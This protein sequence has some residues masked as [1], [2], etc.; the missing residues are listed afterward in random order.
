LL[1]AAFPPL[2]WWPVAFVAVAPL[3]W[4][5]TSAG[6]RR[7]ALLGLAFG[8]G[9]Y[10]ATIY[11]ILLFGELAW[12]ALTLLC[13]ASTALFGLVAPAL[14]RRRRPVMQALG[15]AALW[16]VV[17]WIRGSWPLE[18][19]TWGSLGVS[20][21]DN[22]L[23]VRLATVTGVWGVTFVVVL[24]N[25]LVLQAIVGDGGALRRLARVGAALVL[26]A[27]PVVIPFSVPDGRGLDVATL[28]VDVRRAAVGSSID[29]DLGVARLNMAMHATLADDPPDLVVWGEGALDPGA[30]ND[31]ATFDA[32]RRAIAEV[33]SPTLIGSVLDDPDGTQHTS[34]L[35]FDGSGTPVDRYDKVHLVPFGE[36]VPWRRSLDWISA[37]EQI[38]VDRTPGESVHTVSTEGIPRIGTPICFEN[39]FPSLTRAFVRAGAGFLVVPVNNASYETTAASAQHLQMS[40]MRAV[41]NGRW[42]IDAA[43]S[44]ITAFVDPTGRVVAQ[45]GLFRPAI[46]RHT[47]RIAHNT[48]PYV[49]LGDWFPWLCLAFV[50]GSILVPRGRTSVPGA[51][52][53]LSP[54]RRR[55]IVILPTYDERDTIEWV[56]ARLLALPEHV[57]IMVVD[58]SSPDG[59]GELVRAA[60]ATEPRVRLLSRPTKSGLGSAYM[61]G[62]RAAIDGGYDLIVE[63]DSDLSHQPEELPALL[64]AAGASYDLTIGSRYVPGGSVTDW[65]PARIALSRAGN[66]YARFMLALPVHDATS[67]F[68]VYRRALLQ[69]LVATPLHSDGYGFQIEMVMRAWRG[70]SEIGEVPITFRE[71]EHGRS[72]ISKR[73]VVEA[74]WLVTVWGFKARFAGPPRVQEDERP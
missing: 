40:R 63:M 58:D 5:L 16:T 6:P 41:E 7:G 36:Y 30:T 69:E 52:G 28:Q 66:R 46:V 35:L 31:P 24:V 3:L 61:D 34:V 4:L 42:V 71:R 51:P 59:T 26:I 73:I 68:R 53:P 13:M 25:A 62:F 49:D 74:L 14:C 64:H 67:G 15:L 55:A 8:L 70:G 57:D 9:F 11:W 54:E 47:I 23:T 50:I 19:F 38:P 60:V 65:S 10:G 21:V 22:R 56:L 20:Q 18:G 37:L 27:S 44:G 45:A 1:F 48:T 33:G 43:V 17:E 72:K 32:V 2:G 39:S 29:E 12:V